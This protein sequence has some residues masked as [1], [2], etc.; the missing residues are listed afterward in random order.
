MRVKTPF[1]SYDQAEIAYIIDELVN[2]CYGLAYY[3]RYP[4]SSNID[5]VK[6]LRNLFL[7]SS[8]S[9]SFRCTVVPFGRRLASDYLLSTIPSSEHIFNFLIEKESVEIS[10]LCLASATKP[11]FEGNLTSRVSKESIEKCAL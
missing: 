7:L 3:F 9:I 1:E 8:P 6:G 5:R 2:R 4:S 10:S 11:L